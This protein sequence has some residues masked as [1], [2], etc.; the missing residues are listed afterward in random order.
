MRVL[1]S[2]ACLALCLLV[3]LL[4][5]ALHL[6]LLPAAQ[7]QSDDFITAAYARDFGLRYLWQARLDGW[8]PRPLS[9]TLLFVYERLAAGLLRPLATPFLLLL[10][11]GFVAA[12]LA[13]VR[14]HRERGLRLL[15]G[16]ATA[17]MMLLGHP[18]ADMY[19]WPASAAAYMPTL[20]ASSLVLFLLLDGGAAARPGLL[21]LA[22]VAGAA[23]SEAGAMA[24]LLLAPALA[25]GERDRAR[26]AL[27]SLPTLAV[28]AFVFW[29]LLHHRAAAHVET[30]QPG[31]AALWRQAL[32]T[33]TGDLGQAGLAR[34]LF[35]AGFAWGW[36]KLDPAPPALRARLRLIAFAGCLAIAAG[37]TAYASLLQFGT[38]CCE[39]HDSL[40]QGWLVLALA[41]LAGAW[42][43]ARPILLR[44]LAPAALALACLLGAAPRL[45]PLRHD[46]RVLPAIL[47]AESRNWRSGR[48]AGP[49]MTYRLPPPALVAGRVNLQPGT[50]GQDAR[51][52]WQAHGIML[53]FGKRSL[54]VLPAR[55]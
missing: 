36:G 1:L 31:H 5:L 12:P 17:C 23:S 52:P 44:R 37:L 20:A 24:G 8:S 16:L 42:R 9:E 51:P 49:A 13:G 41:A 3:P 40:R 4:I 45:L 53:F 32:A 29:V 43:P 22:L 18:V 54:T 10:W 2:R 26:M 28:C 19:Y 21:S 6:A 7:W 35:L 38:S 15:L 48:G 34:L 46:L 50:Y 14:R 11:T 30:M 47:R 25:A 27:L 39:R 33:L 55:R